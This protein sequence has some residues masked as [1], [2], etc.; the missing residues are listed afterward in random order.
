[1]ARRGFTDAKRSILTL[2]SPLNPEV[3][4]QPVFDFELEFLTLVFCLRPRRVAVSIV[5]T[6]RIDAQKS[7]DHSDPE[8]N[9]LHG[10]GVLLR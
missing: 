1:M 9:V 5:V 7:N 2:A 3:L 6:E 8:N 10:D 4:A